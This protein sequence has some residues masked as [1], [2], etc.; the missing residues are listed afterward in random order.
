MAANLFLLMLRNLSER[1]F[2]DSIL[3]AASNI[4]NRYLVFGISLVPAA[5][6]SSN[7]QDKQEDVNMSPS[8]FLLTIEPLSN[9]NYRISWNAVPLA[10]LSGSSPPLRH[11]A[12]AAMFGKSLVM[13][14]GF[15]KYQRPLDDFWIL[16]DMGMWFQLKQPNG[17][18]ARGFACMVPVEDL[19]GIYIFAGSSDFAGLLPSKDLW[20]VSVASSSPSSFIVTTSSLS[21]AY[22][23]QRATFSIFATDFFLQKKTSLVCYD[24]LMLQLTNDQSSIQ[25]HVSF[26]SALSNSYGG[27]V[28]QGSYL[29]TVANLYQMTLK[30]YDQVVDTFPRLVNVKAADPDPDFSGLVFPSENGPCDGLSTD[31]STS[32]IIRTFDRNG[33]PGMSP[34]QFSIE[35]FLL[36]D[37]FWYPLLDQNDE[38]HWQ[39][40]TSLQTNIKD[41]FN[42][43]F[44]VT[45]SNTR[46][47]NYSVS[48]LLQG[49]PVSGS[50]FICS[51]DTGNV[52]P[53][54]L[55]INP[56]TVFTVGASSSFF[57]QTVDQFSNNISTPPGVAGDVVTAQLV[58][59]VTSDAA[60]V[61]GDRGQWTMNVHPKVVG[62]SRLVVVVNDL[63]VFE[64]DVTV[65]AL[66]KPVIFGSN[67]FHAINGIPAS[68]IIIAFSVASILHYRASLA[69]QAHMLKNLG[70]IVAPP[71]PVAETFDDVNKPNMADALRQ[72]SAFCHVS[73]F[74]F[75]STKSTLIQI[76]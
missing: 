64:K 47:G 24:D 53:S 18:P 9:N 66:M 56:I 1:E 30:I 8:T 2:G 72:K 33:N 60:V 25:G 21:V 28:Y 13:Y 45:L 50:P 6:T 52:E 4:M 63:V 26:D 32:F 20:F 12:S 37:P 74:L 5:S 35:G 65:E 69:H 39:F 55:A 48:V 23:G 3:F 40:S 10:S 57:I 36:P 16:G 62:K 44:Q 29:P 49:K 11:H 38:S 67:W 7:E 42:G 68:V 76:G 71:E 31:E 34:S 54:L 73:F 22:A 61:E 14:G 27:C 70:D 41:S 75:R 15:D 19:D 51:V 46:S 17:I 58:G 59:E 43:F